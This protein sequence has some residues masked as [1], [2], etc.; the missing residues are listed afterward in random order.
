MALKKSVFPPFPV[1][2]GTSY[3]QRYAILC[4]RLVL[5]QKYTRTALVMSPRGA[6]PVDPGAD[7]DLGFY[8]FLRSFHG[9]LIGCR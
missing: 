5:E 9:H 3:A 7:R 6:G 8:G 2:E 4:E 1:F